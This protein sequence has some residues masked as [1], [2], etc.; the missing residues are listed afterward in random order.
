M[1][2]NQTKPWSDT[3]DG[4][5]D[6]QGSGSHLTQAL[7]FLCCGWSTCSVYSSCLQGDG[8]MFSWLGT[9]SV[10]LA[11]GPSPVLL[12]S[13]KARFCHSPAACPYPSSHLFLTTLL[14][15]KVIVGF[16]WGGEVGRTLLKTLKEAKKWEDSWLFVE[17]I[18]PCSKQIALSWVTHSTAKWRGLMGPP[19]LQNVK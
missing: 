10:H 5:H 15:G 13:I 9:A 19:R 3:Q 8:N 18:W 16:F 4:G 17:A 1:P 7:I 6:P 12:P 2:H 11:L 14:S